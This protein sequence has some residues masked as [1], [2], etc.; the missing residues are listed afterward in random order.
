MKIVVTGATSFIGSALI[1]ELQRNDHQIYAVVRPDSGN[2]DKLPKDKKNLNILEVDLEH[3]E[4]LSSIINHSCDLFFHLGWDGAGSDNRKSRIIQQGNVTTSLKALKSAKALGCKRFLFSG[5]QAEYGVY[6]E[7]VTEDSAC[8]PISEY[9]KA[10]VD[11]YHQAMALCDQWRR[12]GER[13]PQYIHARIFSVYGPGDHP[14]SLVESCLKAFLKGQEMNLG[15]CGQLW[16]YLYIDDLTA[17]LYQLMIAEIGADHTGIY[18]IAGRTDETK[19]LREYIQ[20]IF[21]ICGE[22][23]GCRFGMRAPNAEGEVNL[24]PNTDKIQKQIGWRA[25]IDF[26]KGIHLML[27]NKCLVC[28]HDLNESILELKEMPASAQDIPNI[29]QLDQDRGIDLNLFQCPHC[30]LVQF[31]C[32]PVAY[33]RDVIRSGGF[34]TTMVELR[35]RQYQ[36]LI[37][38]YHLEGKR[39]I[40]VGCGRGEFL[41]VLKDFPVAAFGIEHRPELVKQANE[42]GLTVW[43]RFTEREDTILDP[44]ENQKFDVFLS[45]NFLE[46]QPQ[47]DVM[48]RCIYRNLTADGMGLITVPS[49]EY[50]MEHD[51]YYELIRDHIAYYTFETL[52]YLLESN[53]FMVLEREM[54]NRDTLSVIVKKKPL[55]EEAADSHK[56]VPLN[57]K[58]LADS[59]IVIAD[60][61][62]QWIKA[63]KAAQKTVAIWGASHQGFT[64]AATTCLKDEAEYIIDSAP[65]KQGKY[66]PASHLPIVAPNYFEQHPV[67]AILIVAPGYTEEIARIIANQFG[68]DTSIYTLRSNHMEQIK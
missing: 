52:E 30:G 10:K 8:E 48:L 60:E 55:I 43:E 31:D 18:N 37:Q 57:L 21:E 6:H 4:Q 2:L 47:P 38:K 35:N 67:D 5:S 39:F 28:K 46:H 45:F 11:F 7:A 50:I 65:F 1:R 25:D 34:S 61:I 59:R 33:Y 17:A 41:R 26:E 3:L 54:V 62:E 12:D 56:V 15:N 49:F 9:G 20:Q 44:L 27:K 53:G 42:Q 64:L 24:I 29:D 19:P 14:G 22:L 68:R 16:N 36:H 32:E 13:Y 63:L 58:T 51:G 23:G 66:A 40:E